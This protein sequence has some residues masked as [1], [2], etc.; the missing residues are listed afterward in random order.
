M[1]PKISVITPVYNG[2]QYFD[3]AIPSILNQTLTNFEWLIIDDGSTDSTPQRLAEL[4]HQDTRVRI[5]SPGRLGFV[6]ALNYAIAQAKSEYIAR[7]D[8]D[9]I[10]YPER[11][12][13]QVDFL[14]AHP[15]VGVVGTGYVVQD[16]NRQEQYVRQPPLEHSELLKMMA[17]CVPFAHTLVTFRKQAWEQVGGYPNVKDIEDLR[18]W[19]EFAKSGWQLASI[20][21]TLGKHWVHPKSFWHQNFQYSHRQRVLAK[22]Q[23]KAIQDLKLPFWMA[24]YPLG[25]YVY[26]YLPKQVKSFFRRV[27]AGSQEQDLQSTNNKL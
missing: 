2:E 8:F 23:L 4:A 7:Q 13:Q 17:K 11:L 24:L 21:T 3:R 5:L 12:Q 18:L 6:A 14:D 19:I 16:E 15:H 9:D 10:S 26:L 1:P 20:P 27:I 25:R 22:V